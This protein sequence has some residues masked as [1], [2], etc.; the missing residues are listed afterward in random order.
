ML[1]KQKANAKETWK[2]LNEVINKRKNKRTY[3][4]YFIKS[5]KRI[6]QKEDIA[7]GFNNFFA[8]VGPNLAKNIPLPKN[9]TTI[10]DYLEEIIK[11]T[12][13]LSPVDDL[14]II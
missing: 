7:N 9:D 6:S 11:H 10:Y 3:P 13:F 14:E 12:M 8:N 2:V 1:E 4:E 5:N